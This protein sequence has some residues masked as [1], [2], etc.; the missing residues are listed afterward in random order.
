ML[1]GALQQLCQMALDRNLQ[2]EHLAMIPENV[3]PYIEATIEQVR[4]EYY[5]PLT[6]RE[7]VFVLMIVQAGVWPC[8]R[9]SKRPLKRE[10]LARPPL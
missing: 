1:Q 5:S 7:D 9:R 8:L 3:R 4:A 2:P 6:S 10:I